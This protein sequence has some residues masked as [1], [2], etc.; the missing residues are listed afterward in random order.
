MAGRLEGKAALVTGAA[1]GLGAAAVRRF[2]AEG[3]RVAGLDLHEPERWDEVAAGAPAASFHVCD[4]TDEGRLETTVDAVAA[5]HGSI[6]VLVSCAGVA[7]GGPVHWVQLPDW[8]RVIRVNLTGTFLACKHV[9][10]HMVEQRSGS[11]VNVA[12]VEGIEGTEGGSAYNASKGGVVLL[13][14]NLA[15]DYGRLGIRVNA[16][17]PGFVEGT[18]MFAS[19]M[20]S[21]TMAP[22]LDDYRRAH[23]LGRF[24]RPEELAAAM[25]FLASDDASFVT[26]HALVVDGGFTAGMRTGLSDLMGLT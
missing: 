5:E 25:L 16:V 6:D 26:G 22:F 21:E 8:D 24:G 11:I 17:C 4:V 19:V 15:I 7:G 13:T 18:A 20:G 23:T 9:L 3:A 2:A 10:R 12:S 14:K 1:S